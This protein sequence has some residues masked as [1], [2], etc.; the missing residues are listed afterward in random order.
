VGADHQAQAV[1]SQLAQAIQQRL[2]G[3]VTWQ[4]VAQSGHR[5]EDAVDALQ[6]VSLSPADVL[7]T[8]LGVND[9]VDQVASSASTAALRRLDALARERAGVRLRV[10]CAAPP[11]HVF[12]LLPQPLRWFFGQQAAHLNA[13]VAEDLQTDA[14]RLL[15]RLPS[16]M[17]GQASELMAEDGFH[18]GPAGYRLWAESLAVTIVAALDKEKR[19]ASSGP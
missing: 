11:M 12:P 16:S 5:T 10:H 8:A 3:T 13:S 9:V 19:P 2:G 1:S 18:P 6:A 15:F 17:H 7:V 4:L 14:R